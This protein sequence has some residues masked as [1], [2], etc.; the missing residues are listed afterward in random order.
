[1]SEGILV[2]EAAEIEERRLSAEEFAALENA[3]LTE[4][5]RGHLGDLIDWFLRRYPTPLER[6]RYVRRRARD[7]R[8]MRAH[9]RSHQDPGGVR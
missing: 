2:P 4:E 9:L 7:L 6:L 3:P 1:M 5:E 8:R